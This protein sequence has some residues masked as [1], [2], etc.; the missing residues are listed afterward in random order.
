MQV[1]VEELIGAIE[2][3][4]R[5]ARIVPLSELLERHRAGKSTEGL[6]SLTFDDGYAALP[7]L[8]GSYV[9]RVN[10]PISVFITTRASDQAARFWWD[11]IDDCFPRISP[12]RWRAFENAVG[13]PDAY[14][15]GQ[16]AEYGPLRPLRQ[17]IMA[18]Y[19]G[20][21]PQHLESAL[22][23]LEHGTTSAQRAMSWDEIAA[24]GANGLVEYGVHTLTHPV[25]PLLSDKDF[26]DE[27][28]GAHRELL[29]HVPNA[30]PVLAIPFGLY[31]SRT[32]DLARR[33]GMQTSLTLDNRTMRGIP[34]SAAPPRVS[35]RSGLKKWKLFLRLTVPRK[36]PSGYP[37]LPSATT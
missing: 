28:G 11:R 8:I 18:Q 12:E 23:D 36:P 4:R 33:A 16:P 5:F 6:I 14:R 10:V 2:F 29:A 24:F 32:I 3:V 25:L 22:S 20:R 26:A 15:T 34:A 27:V 17:W 9:S 35:M 21:W 1:P 19:L 31:D 7:A 37:A 30:L 13:V